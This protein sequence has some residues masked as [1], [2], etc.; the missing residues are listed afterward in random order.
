[1]V[2]RTLQEYKIFFKKIGILGITTI[3]V[4]LNQ[5]IL[6]PILTQN[7]TI[8][9]Y[10]IWVQYTI[11]ITLI[12][13]I[14]V[15]GLP[16]T[17]VRFLS[18]FQTRKEIQEVFYSLGFTVVLGSLSMAIFFLLA[19][20]Y[21][22]NILFN[23]NMLI[24]VLLPLSIFLSGLTL[25][26]FDFFRTFQEMKNYS[27]FS[28]AQAYLVVVL[29]AVMV[30]TGYGINGAII[31]LIISQLIILIVMYIPILKKIGFKFPLFQNLREYLNFG[32]P[33]IPTNL[34]FWILDI[35]D[36]YLIGLFLGLSFVS[37]YSAAYLLGNLI[38]LIMSPFYTLLLP[39][40][41]LYHA[42]GR[43]G[44]IK[45]LLNYSI[46]L[47]LIIAI[48]LF[49]LISILSQPLLN[50]L[51]TSEIAFG[52]FFITPLLAL[53]GIFFGLYGIMS[54][55][56]ILERKTRIT[57]NIWI[58]CAVSNL[59]MDITFG[60]YWGIM[61]IAFTS[62][63]VYIFAFG[64]TLYYSFNY[65]HRKFYRGFLAKSFTAAFLMCLIVLMINPQKPLELLL[66][67]ILSLSFY[68]LI[69]WRLGG[70]Q[71]KELMF[72]S[73]FFKDIHS[74]LTRLFQNSFFKRS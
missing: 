58:I 50:I 32:L 28:F 59:L 19:Y 23:G 62:L 65:I 20:N 70:I 21:M 15:L 41:A 26:F 35:T 47:F 45:T 25:F 37:Y 24:A 31:G 16:Y 18:P 72:L 66:T 34:S 6:L 38:T 69:L 36:R 2:V 42:Q 13:A 12:P 29:V 51:S 68:Y 14:A 74:K 27:I 46:K 60:F 1:M 54:Q 39:N 63:V 56:I 67:M 10:G 61:G 52:G 22:S 71:E 57:G 64:I 7:L 3:L 49:F 40:L 53:G 48:P 43:I 4:S 30:L 11:T 55:V 33:T 73:E 17:M 9:E 5:L 8:P 44:N